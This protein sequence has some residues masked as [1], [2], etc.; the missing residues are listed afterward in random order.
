MPVHTAE[1][2]GASITAGKITFMRI[3]VQ[4]L[5]IHYLS[6]AIRATYVIRINFVNSDFKSELTSG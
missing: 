6:T 5:W 3:H 1:L 4:F 2:G